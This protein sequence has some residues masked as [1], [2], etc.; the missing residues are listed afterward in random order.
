LTKIDPWGSS[1]FKNLSRKIVLSENSDWIISINFSLDNGSNFGTFH[2]ILLTKPQDARVDDFLYFKE[3]QE[4]EKPISKEC[5]RFWNNA[6]LNLSKSHR[7]GTKTF[8]SFFE[9]YLS[10]I[11]TN[12]GYKSLIVAIDLQNAS[13]SIIRETLLFTKLAEHFVDVIEHLQIG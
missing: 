3:S 4:N 9:E 5:Q 7:L 10:D 8:N 6:L 13:L 11:H 12:C 2:L 1:K